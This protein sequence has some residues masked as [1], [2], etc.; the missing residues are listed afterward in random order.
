MFTVFEVLTDKL[1]DIFRAQESMFFEM[2]QQFC[3]TIGLFKNLNV[4]KNK[5]QQ[6]PQNLKGTLVH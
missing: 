5:I 1:E 3:K 6:S 4:L 2:I